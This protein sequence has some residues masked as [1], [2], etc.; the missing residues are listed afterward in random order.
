M[1]D[2]FS[3]GDEPGE[4]GDNLPALAFGGQRAVVEIDS[5]LD[6]Y[7]ALFN[8]GAVKCWGTAGFGVLGFEPLV[9]PVAV[10]ESLPFVDL[11]TDRRATSI[12]VG[13]G[14]AC[15]IL[16]NGMLKCWGRNRYGALGL[17]DIEDR[18]DQA[19][20]MGDALPAVDLGTG[21]HAVSVAAGGWHTCALLDDGS[22]KCWGYN[23]FGQLGLGD[24]NNRGNSSDEMG[25]ALPVIDLGGSADRVLAGNDHT[26]A[27]L[28]TGAIKCWGANEGGQLGLGDTN[29]RGDSPGEMGNALPEVYLGEVEVVELTVGS[30]HN[31][32]VLSDESIK[33]WGVNGQGALGLGDEE[34]RGDDLADMGEALPVVDITWD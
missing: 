9:L 1:V 32:A 20:E 11:G 5:H 27:Q 6:F 19:G 16:D 3:L 26:C 22:L 10:D 17:G 18:G 24:V 4:M 21:R 31:C 13:L 30:Y 25:D 28:D 12:T 8:D 7:C 14:H 2:E 34:A 33:C 29:N 15:A 23:D